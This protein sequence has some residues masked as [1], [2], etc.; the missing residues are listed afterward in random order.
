MKATRSFASALFHASSSTLSECAT[1]C[2]FAFAASAVAS[3]IRASAS[4]L[5]S[6]A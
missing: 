5:L 3:A 2:S 4:R 1:V 6:I